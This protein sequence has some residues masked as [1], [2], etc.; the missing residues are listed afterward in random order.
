MVLVLSH[1]QRFVPVW[2]ASFH[3]G[4]FTFHPLA[5]TPSIRPFL[6]NALLT[7]LPFVSSFM[8]QFGPYSQSRDYL[9]S[10]FCS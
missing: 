6:I 2:G 4:K 1:C 8:A 9:L 10:L 3:K 7:A 5:F